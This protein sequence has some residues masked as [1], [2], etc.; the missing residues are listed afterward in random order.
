MLAGLSVHARENMWRKAIAERRA[1]VFV[2]EHARQIIGWIAIGPSRDTDAPP[3]VAEIFAIHVDPEHWRG[4]AGRRLW[5]AARARLGKSS[6]KRVTLWVLAANEPARQYY[7][8]IGFAEDPG[9][10]KTSTIG[11]ADLVEVRYS[12]HVGA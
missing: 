6:F 1:D 12:R 4:G 7:R 3:E 2:A 5:Q 8:A 10:S 9:V 11:G